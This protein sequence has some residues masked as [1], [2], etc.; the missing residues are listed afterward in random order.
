MMKPINIIDSGYAQ[1]IEEMGSRYRQWVIGFVLSFVC[2]SSLLARKQWTEKE[3]W[4][5][6]ERVGVVKGF[7]EMIPAYPGMTLDEILKTAQNIGLNNVR[8]WIPGASAEEKIANLR[9]IVDTA[10]KYGITC[11]PVLTMPIP[12][13]FGESKG[14]DP[15]ALKQMEEYTKKV[16]GAFAKD[17]RVIRGDKGQVLK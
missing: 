15:A 10:E 14:T 4:K 1:R 2:V 3:A 9:R 16:I 13:A 11:S 17:Q 8:F 7:N 6:Q 5:W 12:K